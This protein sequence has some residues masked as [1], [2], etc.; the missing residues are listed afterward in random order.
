MIITR[1]TFFNPIRYINQIKSN[2]LNS[3]ENK[4]LYKTHKRE[5]ICRRAHVLFTKCTLFVFVLAHSCDHHILCCVFCFVF[6]GLVYTMLPVYLD[7]PFLITL[8][9]FSNVYI[10]KHSITVIICVFGILI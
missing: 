4:I 10:T 9:V 5:T 6:H 8:S 1:G 7:C 2:M 3:M